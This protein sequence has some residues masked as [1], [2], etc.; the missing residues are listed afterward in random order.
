MTAEQNAQLATQAMSRVWMR[1]N[2]G[3]A[4]A[5][6]FVHAYEK[7]YLLELRAGLVVTNQVVM[8]QRLFNYKEKLVPKVRAYLKALP[9]IEQPTSLV[10]MHRAVRKWA[11]IQRDAQPQATGKR[12]EQMNDMNEPET[13]KERRAKAEA[14]KARLESAE[15]E[16]KLTGTV[17]LRAAEHVCAYLSKM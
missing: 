7:A 8:A 14:E 10:E 3:S 16:D 12:W 11:E 6:K 5:E 1:P 15:P 13:K 2:S 17:A 9:D 4:G